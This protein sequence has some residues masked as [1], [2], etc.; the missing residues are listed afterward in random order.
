MRVFS[1][2]T[3][4]DST[5]GMW[6]QTNSF[7]LASALREASEWCRQMKDKVNVYQVVA[8]RYGAFGSSDW[9]VTLHF[10]YKEKKNA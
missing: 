7:D 10:A 3:S 2:Q 8:E 1:S 6:A 5:P 9:T 4:F